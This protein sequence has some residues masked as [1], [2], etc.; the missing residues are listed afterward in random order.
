M[1]DDLPEGFTIASLQMV[2]DALV[3]LETRLKKLENEQK[4]KEVK[5]NDI[6]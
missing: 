2:V 3:N 5:Q 1:T 6:L 4:E